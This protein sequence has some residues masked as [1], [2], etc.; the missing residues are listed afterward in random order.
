MIPVR[1]KYFQTWLK[2]KLHVDLKIVIL[3]AQFIDFYTNNPY[4]HF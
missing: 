1:V 2:V 4:H 3:K